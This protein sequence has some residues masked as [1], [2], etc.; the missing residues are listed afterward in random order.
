[1]G[2]IR[3]ILIKNIHRGMILL[4]K[5]GKRECYSMILIDSIQSDPLPSSF[6]KRRLKFASDAGNGEAKLYLNG[7]L[8]LNYYINFFNNYSTNNR[9]FFLRDSLL[10]YLNS[11]DTVS[12][13]NTRGVYK[14]VNDS[15]RT[16]MISH[17]LGL[18]SLVELTFERRTELDSQGRYYIRSY[19]DI[20][21]ETLRSLALPLT[22][23]LQIDKYQ[24][25][26]NYD[27]LWFLEH[28]TQPLELNSN[29]YIVSLT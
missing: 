10:N 21:R 20:F 1:M 16:R 14:S 26:G 5:Y 11:P 29:V 27:N 15:Y 7:N 8:S 18:D 9:Y 24:F 23:S 4:Y 25:G 28:L 19:D 17:I 3:K 12:Q 2:Y 13:Y 22:T 6:V